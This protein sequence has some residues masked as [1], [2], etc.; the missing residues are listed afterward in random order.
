MLLMFQ[1]ALV[2]AGEVYS[3][4]IPHSFRMSDKSVTI[5]QK[6]VV[7]HASDEIVVYASNNQVNTAEKLDFESIIIHAP[8]NRGWNC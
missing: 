7:I 3:F 5:E 4:N 6:A 1:E 2:K 8:S